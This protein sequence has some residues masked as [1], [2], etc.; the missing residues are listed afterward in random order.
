MKESSVNIQVSEDF[1]PL[2]IL[3][4]ILAVAVVMT[5]AVTAARFDAL[6]LESAGCGGALCKNK[7]WLAKGY[8][9]NF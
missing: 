9:E 8:G 7:M 5:V 2:I 1:N 4:F 6:R 3:I